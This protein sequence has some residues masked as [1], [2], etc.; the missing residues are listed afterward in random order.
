MNSKS[1]SNTNSE[2]LKL[3]TGDLKIFGNPDTWVLI[4]KASSESQGW[5][6]STK[7]LSCA[8]GVLIQV[9]TEHRDE[10]VVTACAEALQ[11]IRGAQLDK[12]EN[13]VIEI[14]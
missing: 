1:L 3:T 7:A 12:D 6:K 4:A 11:F 8:G 9:T 10:G 14:I 5:M 2:D 13:G